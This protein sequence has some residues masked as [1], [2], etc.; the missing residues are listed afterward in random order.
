LL[1]H[2]ALLQSHFTDFGASTWERLGTS[3][4]RL[5]HRYWRCFSPTLCNGSSGFYE[6]CVRM[7]GG[8]GITVEETSCQC[9]GDKHC[10]FLVRWRG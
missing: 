10:A 6:E 5:T 7:S 4:G 1:S 8:S 9:R 3:F 2:V